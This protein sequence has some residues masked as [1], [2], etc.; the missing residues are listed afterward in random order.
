M[1]EGNKTI[2][3]RLFEELWN[4]GNPSLADE[5]FARR[6]LTITLRRPMLGEVPRVRRR[7]R[8]SIALLPPTFD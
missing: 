8:R 4:K 2:D 7:E 1:S 3:R 5:L 6:T